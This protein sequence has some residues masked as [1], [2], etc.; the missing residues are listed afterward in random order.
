MGG[1]IELIAEVR[2]DMQAGRMERSAARGG[3]AWSAETEEGK[4]Q[5][6]SPAKS[7]VSSI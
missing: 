4:S 5:T 2:G 7:P 6:T 1:A 3:E